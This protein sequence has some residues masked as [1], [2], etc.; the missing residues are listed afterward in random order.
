MIENLYKKNHI[1]NVVEYSKVILL[2][3][4]A[5]Y[6]TFSYML[7]LY[8]VSFLIMLNVFI[9]LFSLG[10]DGIHG[11]IANNKKCNDSVTRYFFHF[12]IF[13]SYSRYKK[14]HLLHHKYLGTNLDPD[15]PVDTNTPRSIFRA[16]LY[17]LKRILTFNHIITAILFYTDIFRVFSK[18]NDLKYKKDSAQLLIYWF[19]LFGFFIYINK[20]EVFLVLWVF[21]LSFFSLVIEIYSLLQHRGP[22]NDKNFSRNISGGLLSKQLLLPTGIG[23]HALHHADVKIPWYHLEKVSLDNVESMSSVIENLKN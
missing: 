10:H 12:P 21:P 18:E 9:R 14:L 19:L 17:Y 5:Y 23:L 22:S 2:V 3:C 6:L 4:C 11:L 1:K 15:L 20:L 13:F 8:F 16:I 7:E